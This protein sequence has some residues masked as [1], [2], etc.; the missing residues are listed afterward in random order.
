MIFEDFLDFVARNLR[1]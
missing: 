1:I